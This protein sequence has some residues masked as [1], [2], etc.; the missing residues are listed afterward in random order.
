ML[1]IK[2]EFHDAVDGSIEEIDHMVIYND[3]Q[4]QFY[5]DKNHLFN[6][7]GYVFDGPF[8]EPVEWRKGLHGQVRHYPQKDKEGEYTSVW[9]LIQQM[10]TDIGFTEERLRDD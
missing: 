8:K 7:G 4:S 5:T 10:L 6:Y 9:Y 3:G 2:V 1:V